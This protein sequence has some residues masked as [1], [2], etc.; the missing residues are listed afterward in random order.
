MIEFFNRNG[1]KPSGTKLMKD[2]LFIEIR[3]STL[4]LISGVVVQGEIS[5]FKTVVHILTNILKKITLIIRF[6]Q[7]VIDRKRVSS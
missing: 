3:R 1:F 4:S 6:C 2:E 5:V 7:V